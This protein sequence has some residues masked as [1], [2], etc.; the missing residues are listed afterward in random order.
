MYQLRRQKQ[1]KGPHCLGKRPQRLAGSAAPNRALDTLQISYWLL[2]WEAGPDKTFSL[3]PAMCEV[4]GNWDE[5]SDDVYKYLHICI[6]ENDSWCLSAQ[7]LAGECRR[8]VSSRP[9]QGDLLVNALK[10]TVIQHGK[11][12]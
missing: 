7:N 9:V 11:L 5:T 10:L 8:I 3:P 2:H 1:R 6:A 12:I 4:G